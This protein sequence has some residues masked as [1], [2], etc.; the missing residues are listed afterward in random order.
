LIILN[1]FIVNYANLDSPL[2]ISTF[3]EYVDVFKESWAK[4]SAE[5]SGLKIHKKY[6]VRFFLELEEPLGFGN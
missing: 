1:E 6:L 2:Q 5:Q 3:H 4:Y